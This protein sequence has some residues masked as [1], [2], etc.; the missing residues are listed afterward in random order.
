MYRLYTTVEVSRFQ[1]RSSYTI[2]S[3]FLSRS[4]V[5]SNYRRFPIVTDT[6]VLFVS[7]Q[8]YDQFTRMRGIIFLKEKKKEKKRKNVSR[9]S[10]STLY[11]QF[12][13]MFR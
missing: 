2:F 9:D 13:K 5:S 12:D 1:M 3:F 7:R 11:W 10:R 6:V 8:I 4:Y